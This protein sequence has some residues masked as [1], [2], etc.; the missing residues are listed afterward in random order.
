V[1]GIGVARVLRVV[2]DTE[3][4]GA[5]TGATLP[6]AALTSQLSCVCCSA[7][8][9]LSRWILLDVSRIHLPCE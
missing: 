6:S 9:T 2:H 4:E 5:V 8:R 3:W 1:N 7:L